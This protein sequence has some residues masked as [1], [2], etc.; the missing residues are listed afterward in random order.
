M[1]MGMGMETGNTAGKAGGSYGEEIVLYD[2]EIEWLGVKS[3]A[4]RAFIMFRLVRVFH[5]KWNMRNVQV[6]TGCMT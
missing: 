2:Y 4:M 6:V 5:R 1:E 3:N